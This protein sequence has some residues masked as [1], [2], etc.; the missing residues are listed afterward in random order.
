MPPEHAFPVTIEQTVYPRPD[1]AFPNARI[2]LTYTDS[3]PDF[4]APDAAP[5][6]APNILLVLLDDVGFGWMQTF[7]GLVESPTLDRLAARGLR[8]GAFH[9]TAL[10]SPTRAALLTG[11]NHHTVGTG[12][13]QELAT[14]YPGYSGLIPRTTATIAELLH[15]NGYAT[16]WWGKNHN[17]PDNQTSPAGPFDRWPTS[18]G[19]DY[20]YGF[21]GGETD[22]FFPALYRGTTPVEAPTTPEEGYHLTRDL[23][24]DC[25]AWIR[26]QKAIA[27]DRP[28]FTY[29]APGAAHAPHQPPLDW[30]GRHTGMFDMGWDAYQRETYERQLALGVIP[31]ETQRTERPDQVPAWEDATADEQRLY[32]HFAE[33]YADFL[34]HTDHEVGR[35]VDAFDQLGILENTLV[36]Y[37]IGDNGSSAEGGLA[38]TI[39]EM[40]N[41][42][43]VFPSL[44]ETLPRIDEIGLPG[45]AP[46]YPVAWAWAS[47]APYQWTKQIASHFGG[48]RNPLVLSWP[49]R[50][51]DVGSIRQQFHHVIDIAPT[52]LEV[53]GIAQP[54]SVGGVAQRPIEGVSLAYTFAADAAAAPSRRHTQYFEMFGNRAL[55]HDGWIA[56]CRHGRLPWENF[57]DANFQDD[58]WEL[59]DLLQDWSEANDLAAEHPEK[60]RE[61][62]DLF[63]VEAAKYNVL[64]LDDRFAERAD[65]SNRP[66]YFSGRDQVTLWPGMIR[67]PEGSAPKLNNVQHQVTVHGAI[68]QGGAEGVLVALGGDTGGWTLY[69]KDDLLTY[70]YNWFN[71]NRYKVTSAAPLAAGPFVVGFTFTPASDVPGGPATVTLT[72]DGDAAGSS[73][74][75]KQVMARFSLES[76]DV[77]RD[78][79]SPVSLDYGPARSFPFTGDIQRVDIDFPHGQAQHA[80]DEHLRIT[81]ALD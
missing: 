65:I 71:T 80:P 34:E 10:C 42:N 16:G 81:L 40:M 18:M 54:T 38:G 67:L 26:E 68:P 52:L 13:I 5:E 72:V 77:G 35:V 25:I 45:T 60:L 61:L 31:P 6:G 75:E 76:L 44:E 20:F 30:R 62:Q 74:I 79:L 28:I 64:P 66:S 1:Y 51:T 39:N 56:C 3:A 48:T 47:D 21:I 32:A 73:I 15:L 78:C 7:G 57:T 59:Y 41:L 12:V 33:N 69:V 14:G 27:P 58:P 53:A 8:Y 17:V 9:T 22:R 19:F 4:P 46:H 24:D 11:R 70:E 2:G 37:I 63:M 43:G 50:I 55:Y 36:L 49:A 23:A 29:F